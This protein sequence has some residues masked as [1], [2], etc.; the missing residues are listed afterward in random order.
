MASFIIVGKEAATAGRPRDAEVAFLMSCRVAEKLKGAD[1]VE[2]ADAKYQLAA[3]YARLALAPG[4][5]AGADRSEL[6]KRAD[7]LYSESS[8]TYLAKYGQASEKFRFAAE[9]LASVRQTLAQVNTGQFDHSPP[10]PSPPAPVPQEIAMQQRPPQLPQQRPAAGAGEPLRSAAQAPPAMPEPFAMARPQP[11]EVTKVAPNVPK[12]AATRAGPSFDCSRARSWSE[13]TIC[14]DAE[15]AR[16]DRELSRVYAQA[17]NSARDR[18]AFRRQQ[19]QEWRMRDASCRDREC[20]VRWYAHRRYQL[21]NNLDG[22]GHT[23]AA[24]MRLGPLPV[25]GPPAAEPDRFYRG[26]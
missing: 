21:A 14:S 4:P 1:S 5:E 7:R 12:P 9:G 8:Q 22:G 19:D 3:H 16:L 18:A 10:N 26:N 25:W 11:V 6:L 15:L 23:Q 2:S 20:L 24:G 17:R 13:R